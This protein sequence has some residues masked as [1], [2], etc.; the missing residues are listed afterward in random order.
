MPA[1]VGREVTKALG[2]I[3]YFFTQGKRRGSAILQG[4]EKESLTCVHEKGER[5]SERMMKRR[6]MGKRGGTTRQ[7]REKNHS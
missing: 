5:I 3:F 1:R 4:F 2:F 7:G 6:D